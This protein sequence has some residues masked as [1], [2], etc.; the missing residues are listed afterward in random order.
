LRWIGRHEDSIGHY[1]GWGHKPAGLS[2]RFAHLRVSQGP[3]TDTPEFG[4]R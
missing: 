3:G 1:E 2:T 4:L